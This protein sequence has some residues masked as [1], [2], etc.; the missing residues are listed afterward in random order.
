MPVLTKADYQFTVFHYQSTDYQGGNQHWDMSKDSAGRVFIATD[1]GLLLMDGTKARLLK[2]A[3]KTI[4]RSVYCHKNRVYIGSFRDFGYWIEDAK[5]AW[6]YTSLVKD[7]EKLGLQNDEFWKIAELNGKIY[8]QSFGSLFS[9]DGTEI[10]SI[11]LPGNVYFLMKSGNSVFI[12]AFNGG[13][14]ELKNDRLIFVP[15]SDIFSGTEVK[16]VMTL[17]DASSLIAT[18][19][20]GLFKWTNGRFTQWTTE[21]DAQ[22]RD[23]KVNVAALSDKMIYLGTILK[24]LFILDLDGKLKHH[25][26]SANGLQN[27]TFLSILP[28]DGKG[29]WAG[30]DQGFDYVWFQSPITHHH[31]AE[32]GSAYAA[33]YFDNMLFLG[34]NQGIFYYKKDAS[35]NFSDRVFV[36]GSQGQ[37]WSLK[38]ID[39]KLYCGLNNGTYVM[40]NFT[41]KKLGS[42]GGA[43]N[44]KPYRLGDEEV[45]IQSTYTNIVLFK[46]RNDEW[47]PNHSLKGFTAPAR[48]L[49]IDHLGNM[50]LGH[51]IT[52]L[53]LVKTNA[54]F[55]SVVFSKN[56]GEAEGL[57]Q[58]TN[59]VF[60]VDNRIV[61]PVAGRLYQWDAMKE[62]FAPWEVLNEQI[63]G[64]AGAETIIPV[65][66]NR[67]WFVKAREI[68][69]FEI[70]REQATMIARILPEMYGFQLVNYNE[71]IAELPGHEH[72]IC[73]EEGFALFDYAKSSETPN[74]PAVPLMVGQKFS[75]ASGNE[76][77]SFNA[78]HTNN[79]SVSSSCNNVDFLFTTPHTNGRPCFYQ[80][81]LL[82]LEEQWSDWISGGMV[83]YTR[84]PHGSYTFKIR[85]L[86]DN[87]TPTAEATVSFRIRPPW[88]LTWYAYLSYFVLTAAFLYLLFH[89][90]RRRQWMRQEKALKEENE[91]M[92]A[93]SSAAES[94]LIK[95]SNEKLHSEITMKNI[96][97]A[98]N[99]MAMIKKNELLID[100]RNELNLQKEELGTRFPVKYFNRINKLIDNS[101]NS[102][103]DWEMF[104][105]LFDQ[106]H[107]N[108]FKRLK[109]QY[110]E[111]TPSD[112]RLCAYLRMNLT[113]KEIAPLLNI[114]IRGIEEKRYRLRKKLN[115]QT[116]QNLTEFIIN[117]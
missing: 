1:N 7:A 75:S 116:D 35:G 24:G 27:N 78:S 53:F 6:Q 108:F 70:L 100:I 45:L 34:T 18:A 50:I 65:G 73:L 59:K 66:L 37:V 89:N 15:G 20:M 46:K 30:L 19:S 117:F 22:M 84:L 29:L 38:V 40:E 63:G 103:H 4:V 14:Y 61:V 49:E 82:G 87:G 2:M 105:Y 64:F 96:E 71:C 23:F 54:A 60:K 83:S 74:P 47:H 79:L 111:L 9:F 97:L 56:L 114:T 72:I 88:Y 3:T 51:S 104:E 102:E 93:R 67:Y 25:I 32:T 44:F 86:S 109:K 112:F 90:Y 62:R 77:I 43:Y 80:H 8:F 12:Q 16:A 98:K 5:G 17:P 57:P 68:G 91:L 13:I 39:N 99:T 55:D 81:Q 31:D 107:E 58:Q 85:G 48:Y 10:K 113:S 69:L 95:L 21:A 28:D 76:V 115:L 106:A 110:P 33:A 42:F 36:N 52:G 41:L 26:H 101:I 11:P 94:E 92:K